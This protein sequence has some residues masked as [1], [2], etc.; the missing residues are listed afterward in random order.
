MKKLIDSIIQKHR[1]DGID[2]YPPATL[3]KIAD[4]EKEIGFDLPKNFK[5]FYLISDG[6][7]CNEDLFKMIP[8]S[9]M[10]GY[11]K[12][13]GDNWFY[14]SEYMIYSDMW[15]IRYTPSG[16][17]EIFNGSYPDKTM[18]SSLVEFLEK[19]LQGNVFE[20]GGL[21]VDYMTG[22]KKLE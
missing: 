11:P 5:E 12:D 10:R 9:E 7:Y 6:F 17:Y 2:V 19:F 14:F 15:G 21:R 16:K 22:M 18:T 20:K 3:S 13:Y 4:F 1:K 8:I